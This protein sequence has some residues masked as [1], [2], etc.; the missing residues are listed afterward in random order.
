MPRFTA[1]AVGWKRTSSFTPPSKVW[2]EGLIHDVPFLSAVLH[3]ASM[4]AR[5][6]YSHG[7]KPSKNT[8]VA[9]RKRPFRPFLPGA[10]KAPMRRS[11]RKSPARINYRR[12]QRPLRESVNRLPPGISF[13][14]K[15]AAIPNRKESSANP[16]ISGYSGR[17]RKTCYRRYGLYAIKELSRPG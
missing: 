10:F 9:F 7:K 5:I 12:R 1:E 4:A 2:R 14:V 15:G 16:W 8:Y 11:H 17:S 6:S 3:F 13:S